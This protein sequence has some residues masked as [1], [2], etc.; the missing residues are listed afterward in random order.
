MVSSSST[1]TG[2]ELPNVDLT[3]LPPPPS[4]PEGFTAT[5][6]DSEV[7]LNWDDS[8]DLTVSGHEYRQGEDDQI[9]G[10]W[11]S[12][13]QSGAGQ[14]NAASYTA[15]GLTNGTAYT[16]HF[17]A[18]NITGAG[19]RSLS[20]IATPRHAPVFD[21]GGE[22]PRAIQENS[23]GGESIGD[24]VSATDADDGD[25][26]TYELKGRDAE[27]FDINTASG[28]LIVREG[29]DHETKENYSVTVQVTDGYGLT[30]SIDVRVEVE[31][32]DELPPFP[33]FLW[34]ELPQNEGH[35]SL[36]VEWNEPLEITGVPPITAYEIGYRREGSGDWSIVTSEA[37]ETSRVITGLTPN[38]VYEVKVRALNHEGNSGWT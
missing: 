28:Q 5:I 14:V 1:P 36:A 18:R 17:R 35:N 10:D 20:V 19:Q 22:M 15:D 37:P 2:L 11:N 30:N 33:T 34:V 4:A 23:P 21:S 9:L 26:L 24:P 6:G 3:V 31:D 32:V 13:P 38:T 29:L 25:S 27:A 12:T 8:G 7:S 16:F